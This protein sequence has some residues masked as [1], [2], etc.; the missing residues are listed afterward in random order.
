MLEHFKQIILIKEVIH[1]IK[2]S[3]KKITARNQY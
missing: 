2:S 1:E 3:M